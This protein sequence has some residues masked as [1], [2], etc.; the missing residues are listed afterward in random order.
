MTDPDRGE[1]T[2]TSRLDAWRASEWETTKSNEAE[3]EN[4]QRNRRRRSA[5]ANVQPP[6]VWMHEWKTTQKSN[7]PKKYNDLS[8]GRMMGRV[9]G[10]MTQ[11]NEW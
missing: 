10:E 6:R 8:S 1:S 4:K 5:R 3:K 11:S 9:S 7:E 2:T